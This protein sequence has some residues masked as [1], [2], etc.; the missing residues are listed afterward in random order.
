MELD[1]IDCRG[2]NQ[3]E[4]PTNPSTRTG[5]DPET[6]THE[7]NLQAVEQHG[8]RLLHWRLL[9]GPGAAGG[10]GLVPAGL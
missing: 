1:Q 5:S 9:T 2:A 6:D 7:T 4:T 8:R 10:T 3:S